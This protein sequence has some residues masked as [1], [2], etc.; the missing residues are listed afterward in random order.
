MSELLP[1]LSSNTI[2]EEC[3]VHVGTLLV[4]HQSAI[5]LPPFTLL[6]RIRAGRSFRT[7]RRAGVSSF[8]AFV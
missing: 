5:A 4:N 8:R 2:Q 6:L 3:F 7:F 1:T